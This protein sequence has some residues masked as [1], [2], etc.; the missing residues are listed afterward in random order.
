MNHVLDNPI[1]N[2]LNT[3]NAHI[4]QGSSNAKYYVRDVA[5]FAGLKDN[6]GHE[7]QELRELLPEKSVAVLFTPAGINVPSGWNLMVEKK[8]LQMTYETQRTPAIEGAPLVSLD[9][10]DLDKIQSLI[11]LTNPGPFMDRTLEFGNYEGIFDGENL[12][13]MAGQRMKP[14]NYTEISAVCTHPD[15]CGRGYAARLITS[16]VRKITAEGRKPFLHV[17][18]DNIPACKLYGKL[19]FQIRRELLV[20]VVERA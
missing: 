14:G 12:V 16:Q 1:F 18:P 19:G 4:A 15:Y 7:F 3:G 11:S 9:Y 13:A 17:L 10:P 6:T 20:T 5:F 2:A 8:L